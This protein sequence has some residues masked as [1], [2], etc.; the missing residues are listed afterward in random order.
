MDQKVDLKHYELFI[1]GK[2]VAPSTGEYTIDLDPATEEPI[3]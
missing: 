1:D 3:A 2:H